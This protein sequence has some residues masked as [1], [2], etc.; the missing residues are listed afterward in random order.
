MIQ[1][2]SCKTSENQIQCLVGIVAVTIMKGRCLPLKW[3]QETHRYYLYQ[4]SGID[5]FESKV[6]GEKFR[7]SLQLFIHRVATLLLVGQVVY[8]QSQQ[9]GDISS[10]R[11]LNWAVLVLSVTYNILLHFCVVRSD[12]IA[13]LLNG[14]LVLQSAENL[15]Q[16]WYGKQRSITEKVNILLVLVSPPSAFL[17]PL[18]FSFGLHWFNPK[19]PTLIG[20][21]LVEDNGTIQGTTVKLGVVLFNCWIFICGVFGG[22]VGSVCVQILSVMLLRDNIHACWNVVGNAKYS[23]FTRAI[24]YRQMQVLSCLQNDVQAGIPLSTLLVCLITALPMNLVLILRQ[25]WT[26]QNAPT[27]KL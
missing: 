15:S 10:T 11:I 14:L 17:M 16:Y 4:K 7:L 25:P 21:W 5:N 26:Y 18:A 12:D 13:A 19:K 27:V 2:L 8:A 20:Y 9:Q 6:E 24:I 1:L 3:D 22:I 23:Y